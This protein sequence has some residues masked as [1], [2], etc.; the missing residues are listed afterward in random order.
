[1]SI[2]KITEDRFIVPGAEHRI[3]HPE[4]G[5]VDISV[6][7]ASGSYYV[8]CPSRSRPEDEIEINEEP[9]LP[10]EQ[11]LIDESS[12]EEIAASAA[13]DVRRYYAGELYDDDDERRLLGLESGDA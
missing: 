7:R 12:D 1:M 5:I 10:E 9:S 11:R 8:K 6:I 3:E 13:E 4:I 2:E